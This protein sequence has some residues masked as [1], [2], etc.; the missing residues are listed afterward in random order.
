[1]RP[2]PQLKS[3]ESDGRCSNEDRKEEVD[4]EVEII[5]LDWSTN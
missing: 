4:E 3:P 5:S 1:M 2:R